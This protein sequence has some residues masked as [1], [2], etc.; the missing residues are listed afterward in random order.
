MLAVML[1]LRSEGR[2]SSLN[3]E[4]VPSKPSVPALS[5]A[6]YISPSKA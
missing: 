1:D 6:C 3:L 5:F 2:G 4:R